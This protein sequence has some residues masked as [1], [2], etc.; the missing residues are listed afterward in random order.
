MMTADN[1]LKG[2]ISAFIGI[3]LAIVGID[4][5]SGVSRLTFGFWQLQAGLEVVAISMAFFAV[6]EMLVQVKGFYL[7]ST[8]E[9]RTIEDK[10]PLIPDRETLRNTGPAF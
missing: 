9:Q 5:I 6:R 10:I 7:H 3:A 2:F 1:P 4:T 8:I